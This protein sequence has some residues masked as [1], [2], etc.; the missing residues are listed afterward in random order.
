MSSPGWKAR[1]RVLAP[2][3]EQS[4]HMRWCSEPDEDGPLGP[5]D[6]VNLHH[7]HDAVLPQDPGV[8]GLRNCRAGDRQLAQLLRLQAAGFPL[9]SQASGREF[10]VL[11]PD[12]DDHLVEANRLDK[13]QVSTTFLSC[14]TT[15]NDYSLALACCSP[16]LRAS[17]SLAA[18]RE[19]YL[20]HEHVDTHEP[21]DLGAT[22]IACCT[23]VGCEPT[24]SIG[25][26]G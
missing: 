9:D 25:P 1:I 17:D 13:V 14:S 19:R 5:G 7:L 8:D 21:S 22:D 3:P 4:G 12:T 26:P 6:R 23:G 10:A 15:F 24:S 11:I 16:R 18:G 20:P 2:L